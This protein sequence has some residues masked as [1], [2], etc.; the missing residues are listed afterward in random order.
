MFNLRCLI[1]SI[2]NFFDFS[3]GHSV[4]LFENFYINK[5][6][7]L[8]VKSRFF[9]IYSEGS[10]FNY[11][12]VILWNLLISIETFFKALFIKKPIVIREFSNIP[13]LAFF[14][15]YYIFRKKLYFNINHNLN[16]SLDTL[17]KSIILLCRMGF[18]FLLFDG[19]AL[20][21]V[22]PKKYI[23]N[24]HFAL[25][26]LIRV[27][28]FKR[29]FNKKIYNNRAIVGV[30]GNFRSEKIDNEKLIQTL[31]TIKNIDGVELLLG[32][33]SFNP[34]LESIFQPKDVYVTKTDSDYLKFLR[35]INYLLIFAKKES[36]FFRHS[37]TISDAL[38]NY[39][40]PIVPAYPVF[41]SQVSNPCKVGYVYNKIEELA[42][43]FKSVNNQY[44][45]KQSLI[46]KYLD[47]RGATQYLDS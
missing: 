26:P 9:Q 5:T 8:V 29:K 31:L 46:K 14:W 16:N 23:S 10:I 30:V 3:D 27:D 11:L 42:V 37:G 17:P 34:N 36:Y 22:I 47:T 7:P 1:N 32:S 33:R 6:K 43:I 13:T 28:K 25:F 41:I 45:K 35:K 15:I 44:G 4:Y 20:S 18:N 12:V 24:F 2:T 39:V 40:M 19:Y 38:Q 21:K